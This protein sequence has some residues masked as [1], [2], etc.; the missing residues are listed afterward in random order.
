MYSRVK[1]GHIPIRKQTF[2]IGSTTIDFPKNVIRSKNQHVPH[3]I[4]GVASLKFLI[5]TTQAQKHLDVSRLNNRKVTCSLPISNLFEVPLL[6]T[7]KG[8]KN[9]PENR[10]VNY[11]F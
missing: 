11:K 4:Y 7:D 1:S 6:I 5:W 2:V 8:G 3:R 9:C 10:S